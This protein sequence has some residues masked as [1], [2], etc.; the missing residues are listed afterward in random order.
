[1][2]LITYNKKIEVMFSKEDELILDGQSRILNWLYNQLLTLCK[3]DYEKNNNENRFLNDRNLRN[4]VAQVMKEKHP[5]LET[6]HSSPVKEVS[7]RL[8]DAFIRLFTGQNQYPNYRSWKKNWYSL[9]F[10][11][12]KKGWEIKDNKLLIM[13]GKIPDLPIPEGKRNPGIYGTLQEPF[14]LQE[15]E[16]VKTCRLCKQ[17]GNRFYV[18]ITIERANEEDLLFKEEVKQYKKENK[19]YNYLKKQAKTKEEKEALPP[20]PVKPVQGLNMPKS[21]TWIALDPNHKNFFVGT[22]NEGN[23]VEWQKLSVIKYWDK[24]IDEL[25]SLRD[26]CE[27]IYRKKKTEHG[28]TYTVHSPRWNKIN[29]ALNKAYHCRR[30]QIKTMMFTIAHA[31]YQRYDVVLIGDYTPNNGT[32]P[33]DSMKR[34]MLNQETIGSFR[35]ILEWVSKK[36]EKHYKKV[37]ERNTTKECCVCGHQEKK[38]P[39][40]REFTCKTCNAKMMRDNNAS[41]NIAK[42][43]GFI[44]DKKYIKN[45]ATFTH[46]GYVPVGQK[47]VW[48]KNF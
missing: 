33:F 13:L 7:F 12:P 29:N 31:L 9:F 41:I 19:Q 42:K 8:K 27:K 35:K 47:V 18:I 10:D 3:D 6:V 24:K 1:M 11:E 45:L 5:F 37:N 44:L 34:S 22:D 38:A 14:A 15:D 43:E 28:N 30:E 4:Y 16:K 2:T 36:Y 25:K 21:P 23:S 48:I 17:Q 40:V 46:T 20:K 26:Q 39:S 32:A